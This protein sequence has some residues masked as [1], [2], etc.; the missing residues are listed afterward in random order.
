[1]LKDE[2]LVLRSDVQQAETVVTASRY[3]DRLGLVYLDVVIDKYQTGVGLLST[4]C[5][6]LTDAIT[7]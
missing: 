7:D 1:L 2:E 5:G 3:D 4:T 6:L